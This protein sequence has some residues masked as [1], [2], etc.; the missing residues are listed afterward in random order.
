MTRNLLEEIPQLREDL[1]YEIAR[2]DL[3]CADNYRAAIKGDDA[4]EED[5]NKVRAKGCCGSFDT[6]TKVEG[7]EYL[8]GCNFG[9]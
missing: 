7:V 3:D 5:Y 4:S 6:T 2:H 8:I 9:H 1:S